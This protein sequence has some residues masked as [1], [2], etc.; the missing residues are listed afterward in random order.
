[1]VYKTKAISL[2]HDNLGAVVGGKGIGSFSKLVIME[3]LASPASRLADEQIKGTGSA[4]LIDTAGF[5]ITNHH[6]IENASRIFIEM[7]GI[8]K[9]YEV[10]EVISD[11][12]NDLSLLQITVQ[13]L[14]FPESIVYQ[15]S[16][17]VEDVG[18]EIFTLGY[19]F[20]LSGLGR[21]I[22]FA[23][24]KVS[25][26]TGFNNDIALYQ[27]TVPIQPGNSG[28]PLFNNKGEIIGC[29]NAT[30]RNAENVSYAIKSSYIRTMVE[31]SGKPVSLPQAS[32]PVEMKLTEKVKVLSKYIGIVKGL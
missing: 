18:S 6:V 8:N 26:R 7:P 30:F 31:S 9:T 10:R 21:E 20:V 14:M 11:K 25:S 16:T 3:D 12:T 5:F 22:K 13:H 17:S 15:L 1:M 27:T 24:G 23:D 32:L 29:I 19:P 4:F 2:S 28:S